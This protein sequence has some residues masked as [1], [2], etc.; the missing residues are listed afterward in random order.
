MYI[1]TMARGDCERRN[2]PSG[3]CTQGG[4][5]VQGEIILVP[6]NTTK[7]CSKGLKCYFS[8]DIQRRLQRHCK[9]LVKD[10]Q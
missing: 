10:T 7:F 5:T 3:N 8:H 6:C 2:C 4:E 1:C 9:V